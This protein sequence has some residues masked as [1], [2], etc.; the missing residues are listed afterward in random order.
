VQNHLHACL[1]S[2]FLVRRAPHATAF[3]DRNQPP[4]GG[5]LQSAPI[6]GAWLRSF[7]LCVDMNEAA[8]SEIDDALCRMVFDSHDAAQSGGAIWENAE[9]ILS[10]SM[11]ASSR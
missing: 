8:D 11:L 5:V 6:P 3:R 9:E 4:C 2:R 10:A 7:D 1:L